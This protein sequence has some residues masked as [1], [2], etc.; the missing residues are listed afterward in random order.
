M[1]RIYLSRDK[2]N[3]TIAS[4][5]LLKKALSAAKALWPDKDWTTIRSDCALAVDWQP[6]F[7]LEPHPNQT[8]TV[9]QNP[10]VVAKYELDLETFKDRLA[11]SQGRRGDN[12]QWSL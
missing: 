12:I 6:V 8:Y 2:S 7:L 1:V 5:I 10:P 3:K 11:K 4:E 9:R